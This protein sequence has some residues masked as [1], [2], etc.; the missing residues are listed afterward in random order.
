MLD[1]PFQ[2]VKATFR[3]AADGRPDTNNVAEPLSTKAK[4]ECYHRAGV[5]GKLEGLMMSLSCRAALRNRSLVTFLPQ[6]RHR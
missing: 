6:A 2:R 1:N 4:P 3:L 5:G